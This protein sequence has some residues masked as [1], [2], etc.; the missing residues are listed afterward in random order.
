MKNQAGPGNSV[1]CYSSVFIQAIGPYVQT[2]IVSKRNP[3][4]IA[5]HAASTMHL[6]IS[7]VA[8]LLAIGSCCCCYFAIML[9]QIV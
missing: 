8:T 4:F 7:F 2:V 3:P 9:P 6:V 1:G 5:N